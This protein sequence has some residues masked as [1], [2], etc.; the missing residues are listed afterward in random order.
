MAELK[1]G[2]GEPSSLPP[3]EPGASVQTL[4]TSEPPARR[5]GR[6]PGS[7]N[8]S[9]GES[10]ES[11]EGRL[12]E[13]L[14]E[15]MVVPIAFV[16]PLAAANIEAR[17]ERTAKAAIRL[18]AK[19][20]KVKKGIEKIIDGS[21][22]FTVAMFPLSTAVCVMV[23]WGMLPPLSPP[24]RAIGVPRLWDDAHPEYPLAQAIAD[25]ELAQAHAGENGGSSA[26]D[27]RRGIDALIEEESPG[28]D[29][30]WREA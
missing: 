20:P 17:A 7:K 19:N 16:S 22:V 10:L 23:D 9:K 24:A 3:P 1:F 8:R 26:T 15:E 25:A 6:P 4:E 28:G 27:H 14:L 30:G 5:R 12:K 11:L 29:N 18:A 2:T 21:D 13:K